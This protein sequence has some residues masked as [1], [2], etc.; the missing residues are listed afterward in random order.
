MGCYFLSYLQGCRKYGRHKIRRG[1]SC[2]NQMKV[3]GSQQSSE[4]KNTTLFSAFT[5]NGWGLN[6]SKQ[7][8]SRTNLQRIHLCI[9][10]ICSLVF[11]H[12]LGSGEG[13]DNTLQYSCLGNPMDRGAWRASVY[14]VTRN[15]TRLSD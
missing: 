15:S 9:K 14:G 5:S 7:K 13:N 8:N 2:M 4:P 1:F 12:S 6:S 11:L 10:A 3:C